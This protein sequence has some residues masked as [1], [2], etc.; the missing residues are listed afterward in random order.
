MRKCTFEQIYA[1]SKDSFSL[2]SVSVAA[3][4]TK[5]I[6]IW[7]SK[8]AKVAFCFNLYRAVIDR[9]PVLADMRQRHTNVNIIPLRRRC[10]AV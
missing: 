6:E 8:D 7:L 2:I 5:I 1:P 10:D 9:I 4:M 3:R